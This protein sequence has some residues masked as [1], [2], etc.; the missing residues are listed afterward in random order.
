MG[1]RDA[2]GPYEPTGALVYRG[3]CA[4]P[5]GPGTHVE[6]I[7]ALM[8]RVSGTGPGG[9][10]EIYG[11]PTGAEYN[12]GACMYPGGGCPGKNVEPAGADS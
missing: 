7:G 3:A 11:E 5:G 1:G 4:N 10:P 2:C 8:T 6:P 9:G 12:R